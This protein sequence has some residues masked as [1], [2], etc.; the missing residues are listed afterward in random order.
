MQF[1]DIIGQYAIKE[2]LVQAVA[3]DRIPHAQLLVGPPGNGKIALALA[4]AQYVNSNTLG[5][6]FKLVT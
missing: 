1:Q 3:E 4:F 6:I 2:R 5:K